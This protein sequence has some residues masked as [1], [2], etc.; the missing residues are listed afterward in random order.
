MVSDSVKLRSAVNAGAATRTARVLPLSLPQVF[1]MKSPR[2]SSSL[3]PA[4]KSGSTWPR[5]LT[6]HPAKRSHTDMPRTIMSEPLL[7]IVTMHRLPGFSRFDALMPMPSMPRS[8]ISARVSVMVSTR[9]SSPLRDIL[10][11]LRLM[12]SGRPPMGISYEKRAE[13]TIGCRKKLPYRPERWERLPKYDR[14]TQET[15]GGPPG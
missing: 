7:P 6:D 13:R 15:P 2:D 12:V 14:V 10:L 4:E 8:A 9:M 1:V 11:C 5:G 3:I